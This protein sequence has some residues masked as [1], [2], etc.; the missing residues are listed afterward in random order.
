MAAYVVRPGPGGTR[1]AG[2]SLLW[3]GAKNTWKQRHLEDGSGRVSGIVECECGARSPRI[4]AQN[5]AR[6]W[7][8]QHKADVAGA[9]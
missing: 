8:A 6:R 4:T 7:M 3:E 2:H 9:L 5:Q 1:L